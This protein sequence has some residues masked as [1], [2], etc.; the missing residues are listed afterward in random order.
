[1]AGC[2]PHEHVASLA[3]MQPPSRPQQVAGTAA[4]ADAITVDLIDWVG[5]ALT[6]VLDLTF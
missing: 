1:M 6:G 2:L 4:A 3:Q 5:V